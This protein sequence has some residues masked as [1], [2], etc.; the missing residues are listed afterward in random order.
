VTPIRSIFFAAGALA[1]IG[2]GSA[3]IAD[4]SITPPKGYRMWFH[5]NTLVV[6]KQSPLFEA[7]GGINNVYLSPGGV[8]MLKNGRPYPDGTTFVDDIHEFTVKDGSYFEGERK[9]LAVMVRNTK[10]YAATGGWGFQAWAAGD[11][12]KP[13]VTDPVKQCFGCHTQKIAIPR[14]AEH[15]YVFSTYIP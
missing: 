14:L 12:K 4:T 8:A 11:P 6:D 3:A 1:A 2:L 15:Q 13:L 7:F 10:K 9:V 5:V